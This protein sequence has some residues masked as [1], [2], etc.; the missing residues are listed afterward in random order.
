M[1]TF[2][3]KYKRH[4]HQW[5]KTPSG[6]ILPTAKITDLSVRSKSNFLDI[7]SRALEIEDLYKN[8][9]IQLNS[10]S[11]I[12]Q[13][14]KYAKE[15][16]D[17]FLLGKNNNFSDEVFFSAMHLDRIANSILLLENESNKAHF[18]KRLKSGGLNFFQRD[19]SDA[20]DALWEI[21]VW[22]KL[23]KRIKSACLE[24]PPDVVVKFEDS[25]IG[26][27]CKKVYSE[28]HIQNVL[29]KAVKQIEKEFE[30][31]IIA[32]NLDDLLPS[33]KVLKME[34]SDAVTEK[35]HGF[36]AKFI[37]RHN[38]HFIK[39]FSQ[40]RII[41]IIVSTAIIADVPPERPR[42]RNTYQ[43]TVW[44]ATNLPQLYKIQLE[45]FYN[46]VMN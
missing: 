6:I 22:A 21:E 33:N 3:G 25:K 11:G 7:K 30:F 45:K 24:E 8:S 10:R 14:I 12:G 5:I 2:S 23:R 43:W 44:T 32:I 36:N 41:S 27:S 35:L 28:K 19:K 4:D 18:L 39:Y 31:G 16:S 1:D 29:S 40:T 9:G 46:L 34:S 38:R 17:N 15:L 37:D 26:I 20:K 42:F 13:L